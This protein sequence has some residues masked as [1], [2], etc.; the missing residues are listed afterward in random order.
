MKPGTSA[1]FVSSE[2]E[3]SLD[4][5][6]LVVDFPLP[7]MLVPPILADQCVSLVLRR[8]GDRGRL[9][10][11]RTRRVFGVAIN[12]RLQEGQ[13]FISINYSQHAR[14]ASDDTH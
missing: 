2:M 9:I 1:V 6:P 11:K 5:A 12:C 7:V 4:I 10:F 3:S 14:I 8:G 13:Y